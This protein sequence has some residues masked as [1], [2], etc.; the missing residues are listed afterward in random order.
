MI[1]FYK[2]W[3]FHLIFLFPKNNINLLHD[4]Y[5]SLK[6]FNFGDVIT[7]YLITKYK[8]AKIDLIK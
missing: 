3:L 5:L 2:G 4:P 7:I 1:C 8:F 6:Q